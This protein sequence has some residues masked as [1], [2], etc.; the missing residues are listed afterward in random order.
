MKTFPCSN[1]KVGILAIVLAAVAASLPDA[2]AGEKVAIVNLPP[3]VTLAI[4]DRFPDARF[5]EAE[6][7][8]E[9]GVVKYEVE[10]KSGGKDIDIEVAAD[11]RILKI[12]D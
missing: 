6:A 4:L 9:N 3:P 1:V 11:G 2:N 7:E 10:I 12:D 8:T 5:T